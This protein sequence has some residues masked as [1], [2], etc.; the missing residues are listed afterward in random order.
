MPLVIR[1]GA[2]GTSSLTPVSLH[3]ASRGQSPSCDV[4]DRRDCAPIEYLRS[5]RHTST[6]VAFVRPRASTGSAAGTRRSIRA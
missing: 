5:R 4:L 3:T 2:V 1:Q 6:A